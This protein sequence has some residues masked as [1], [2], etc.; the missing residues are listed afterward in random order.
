MDNEHTYHYD[1]ISFKIY[2]KAT[3]DTDKD[4]N[5]NPVDEDDSTNDN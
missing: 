5:T 1:E 4:S 2:V 3:P